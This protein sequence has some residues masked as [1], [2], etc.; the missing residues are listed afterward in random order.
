MME[1]VRKALR[2]AHSILSDPFGFFKSMG[3]TRE[4]G[5]RKVRYVVTWSSCFR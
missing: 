3:E 4:K 1:F 5:P 2:D